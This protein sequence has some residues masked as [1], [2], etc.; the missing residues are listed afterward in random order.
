MHERPGLEW[1]GAFLSLV[2]ELGFGCGTTLPQS[3]PSPV[4]RTTTPKMQTY[5]LGGDK[6]SGGAVAFTPYAE[7]RVY[8]GGNMLREYQREGLN[9]LLENWHAGRSCI[10]ADE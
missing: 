3:S 7:S 6:N 5:P 1:T 8:K 4:T 2:W 9:W 10:L